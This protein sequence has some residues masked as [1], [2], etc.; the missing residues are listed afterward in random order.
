MEIPSS[1]PITT[2]QQASN[3]QSR[4]PSKMLNQNDFLKLVVAQMANQDP[5]K[6][7]SDTEFIAQMTQ[8]TTLEQT[9]TMQ[10]DIA[11]MRAQQE[12]LQG[13]ALM[14]RE[15][16][17]KSGKLD[18][19][20]GVVEGLEMEGDAIKVKVGGK[21]YGLNEVLEVRSESQNLVET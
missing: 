9:K 19:V 4:V 11:Q 13:M 20:Q 2:G 17:V 5:M 7:Q 15:V 12:V 6:P 1:S 16:I 14:N 8:F 18:P 10:T 21:M 3:S